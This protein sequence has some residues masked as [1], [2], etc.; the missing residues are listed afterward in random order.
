MFYRRVAVH[1]QV[2]WVGSPPIFPFKPRD[3]CTVVHVRR[4][5]DG[6]VVILNRATKHRLAPETSEYQRAAITLAANI[7]QP[8]KGAPVRVCGMI[9]RRWTLCSSDA[10]HS[11][12]FRRTSPS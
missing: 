4:L 10:W 7:I 12:I 9:C 8:V 6:T 5:K 1:V 3:F 2:V 11:P